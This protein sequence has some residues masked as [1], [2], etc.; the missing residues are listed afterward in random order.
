MKFRWS[1]GPN[2]DGIREWSESLLVHLDSIESKR[3]TFGDDISRIVGDESFVKLVGLASQFQGAF[4]GRA[5]GICNPNPQIT[6]IAL[7]SS[8]G[9]AKK[10]G[11]GSWHKPSQH[12]IT[13]ARHQFLRNISFILDAN[14]SAA[15]NHTMGVFSGGHAY[16]F[17]ELTRKREAA[18]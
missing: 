8:S 16:Y 2:F 3:Q 15:K 12:T 14:V 7:R 13:G 1:R 5:G 11:Q 10:Q 4:H 9:W 6:G 18:L 17:D